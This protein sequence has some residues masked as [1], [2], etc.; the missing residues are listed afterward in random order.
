[1]GRR[2]TFTTVITC[3]A[4]AVAALGAMPAAAQF[5]ESYNFLKAVREADGDKVTKALQDSGPTMVNTR[6]FTTGEGALLIVIKR[7]DLNWLRFLLSKGANPN[8]RDNAG[9]TPLIAATQIGFS[10]GVSALIDSKAQINLANGGGET[11]LIIA[12][13]QRNLPLVRLMLASGA[14]PK[15]ADRIAG[16]SALDY[17]TEDPRSGAVLKVLKEAPAAPAAKPKISGPG[18]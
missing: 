3:A 11:P 8:I 15:Q 16:K 2:R 6:E 4:F 5:S 12:T 18:L 1:M 10:E 7:R 14:D 17:A 13:Q 9:I